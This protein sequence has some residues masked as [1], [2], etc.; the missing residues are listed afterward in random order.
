MIETERL[1]LRPW[2]EADRDGFVAMMGDPE[3]GGWLGGALTRE[4]ADGAFDRMRAFLA[5][6]GHGYWAAERKADGLLLGRIG[7]RRMPLDWRHPFSGQVEVGWA[8][9][10]HAWGQ[11]YAAEGAAAALAWGFETLATPEIF[12]FT[13]DTNA[14]SEAVMRRIGMVRA[15]DRD[16][17]HP[18]L[19][20]DH[21]LRRHV[22]Y[23]A[24][25]PIAAPTGRS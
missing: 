9:A 23:V 14:R 2:T 6:N 17:D 25:R 22:V 7:A 5:E 15:A 10:R 21:P 12:S 19:A 18:D 24:R 16:F 4:E 1:V 20:P 11:G 8:L 3:V 13:A